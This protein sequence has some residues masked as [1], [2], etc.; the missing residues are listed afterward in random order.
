[1]RFHMLRPEVGSVPE[2]EL[3][4]CEV[5]QK[6]EVAAGERQ[7]KSLIGKD[8]RKMLGEDPSQDSA[9]D[10]KNEELDTME[11]QPKQAKEWG[12]EELAETL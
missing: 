6:T 11:K 10:E 12:F 2:A 3:Q 5:V 8:E 4:S 9:V 7:E 1:M